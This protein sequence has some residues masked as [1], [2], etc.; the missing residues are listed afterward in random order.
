MESWL[1]ELKAEFQ[2]EIKQKVNGSRRKK[3]KCEEIK[4]KS[5]IKEFNKEKLLKLFR[6]I[7]TSKSGPPKE[8]MH[9]RNAFVHTPHP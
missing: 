5:L 8:K 1:V 7:H 4:T 9:R 3:T 2:Y 6:E